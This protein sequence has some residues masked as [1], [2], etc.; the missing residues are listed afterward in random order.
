M[1]PVSSHQ[2]AILEAVHALLEEAGLTPQDL[3]SVYSPSHPTLS[4]SSC[5]STPSIASISEPFPAI[6]AS[7]YVPPLACPFM[8]VELVDRRNWINKK[9]TADAIVNHPPSVIIEYPQTGSLNGQAVAHVFP[10]DPAAFIHPK[11]SF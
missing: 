8:A 3:E 7:C 5:A 6:V 10:V 9:Q 11:A 1:D 4:L 2:C